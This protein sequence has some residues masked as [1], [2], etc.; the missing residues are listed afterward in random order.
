MSE[1]ICKL[2]EEKAKN[3]TKKDLYRGIGWGFLGVITLL[4]L[5]Q[6]L[7]QQKAA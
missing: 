5:L 2:A 1:N 6:T 3:L 7:R 4:N